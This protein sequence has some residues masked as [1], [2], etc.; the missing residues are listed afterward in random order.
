MLFGYIWVE[1]D[2]NDILLDQQR[3]ALMIA[4][5][6]PDHCYEEIGCSRHDARPGRQDCLASLN[7]GDMLLVWQLDRLVDSRAHFLEVLASIQQRKAGLKVLGGKGAVIDSAQISLDAIAQL[8]EAVAALEA[9]VNREASM[10]GRAVAKAKGT[11][12]GP[13]HKVTATILR[14][15]IKELTTTDISFTSAAEKRGITRATLYNYLN[16]DGSLK[17]AG[18]AMLDANP[19][20]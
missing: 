8:I 3:Q 19:Q 14:E 18:Q 1:K 2:G 9:Q 10:A 5:V 4:G 12:F 16:G 20:D 13:K 17:P 11:A 7:A 6:S 15:I